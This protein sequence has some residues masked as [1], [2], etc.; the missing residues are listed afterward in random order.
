MIENDFVIHD[1]KIKITENNRI[2]YKYIT[3][4]LK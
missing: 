3:I 2:F 1:N 4:K